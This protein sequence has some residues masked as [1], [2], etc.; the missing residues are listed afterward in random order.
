MQSKAKINKNRLGVC[1]TFKEPR[2]NDI[3]LSNTIDL[4]DLGIDVSVNTKNKKIPLAQL[5]NTK[6]VRF[7]SSIQIFI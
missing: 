1:H 6:L 3:Y 4:K 5:S 2:P 7:D